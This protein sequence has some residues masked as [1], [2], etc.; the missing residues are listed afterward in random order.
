MN[1]VKPTHKL[2]LLSIQKYH[3]KVLIGQ[4]DLTI[5]SPNLAGRLLHA[6]N[7]EKITYVRLM[8]LAGNNKVPTGIYPDSIPNEAEL[9]L[10]RKHAKVMQEVQDLLTKGV[11]VRVGIVTGSCVSQTLLV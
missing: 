2:M 3:I 4:M 10:Y 9:L 8:G 1:A 7:W 11:V 5:K 6:Y